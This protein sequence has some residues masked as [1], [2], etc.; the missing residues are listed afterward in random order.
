MRENPQAILDELAGH[1]GLQVRTDRR[2][3][4]NA[5]RNRVDE[6]IRT[7]D[8]RQAGPSRA[9]VDAIVADLE[10]YLQELRKHGTVLGPILNK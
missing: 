5:M 1:D 10:P 4:L 6:W 7:L 3:L 9:E 2:N 8:A